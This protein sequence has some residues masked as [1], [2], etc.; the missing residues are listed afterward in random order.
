MYAT[1]YFEAAFLNAMKGITLAAPSKFYIGLYVSNPGESGTNGIEINY[2]GYAR[3]PITFSPPA[4]DSAINAIA[5]KNDTEITF[6]TTKQD[7]GMVTHIGILD[8]Q[9]GGNMW[10]YGEAREN[11]IVNA[12][13][14]PVVL[15]QEIIYYSVGNLSDL[16]KTALLNVIRGQSIPG[17]TP[18]IA[19]FNGNPNSGGAELSGENYARPA[20]EFATPSEAD[21]GQMQTANIAPTQFNRPTTAWGTWNYT[22][23]YDAE[24]SGKPVWIVE[25]TPAKEIKK[26]YMPRV[27]EGDIKVAI[28]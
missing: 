7:A 9:V 28:N 25:K 22:A 6:P 23:I 13:E 24:S 21:S 10:L 18:H 4:Q 15:A 11:L 12:D 16:Y 3:Q 8:S 20:L 17:Y 14:A 1:N 2:P 19:L 5:I 27:A 26:G